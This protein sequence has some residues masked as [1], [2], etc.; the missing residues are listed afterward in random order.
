MTAVLE[1]VDQQLEVDDDSL[2][3]VVHGQ[4]KEKASM[5][6]LQAW[7]ASTLL[8]VL[9]NFVR[10]HR[11]GKVIAESLFVLDPATDSQRR[12]DLAFVSR[13]RVGKPTQ[14]AAWDVVPDLAVEVISPTNRAP[15]VLEKIHEYFAAGVQLVWVVYCQPRQVYV[16][17]STTNI[18]VLTPADTLEGDDVITG[19]TLPVA[20]LFE[21]LDDIEEPA[22]RT[23]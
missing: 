20:K 16:Y 1:R 21:D 4:R 11:L 19:F 18:Q 17:R 12:P 3:E 10:S 6:M 22:V 13:Q 9:D 5:G 2:Y 15:E 14:T 7:V 8:V 23:E